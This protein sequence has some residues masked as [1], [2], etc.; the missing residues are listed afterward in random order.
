[1]NSLGNFGG[2]LY[3]RNTPILSFKF[4]SGMLVD[5]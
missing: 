2:I 1:M 4:K 3:K 5:V